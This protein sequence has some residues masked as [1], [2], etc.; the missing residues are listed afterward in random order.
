MGRDWFVQDI[1]GTRVFWHAGDTEGQHAD[2]FAIPDQRFVLVVLTNG[3][4]G[5]SAAA[6]AA[7]DAALAQFPALAPL[8]DTIGLGHALQAPPDAA[9]ITLP[10][11][12]VA[13]YA[14]RYADPGQALTVTVEGTGP[15]LS[16]EHIDQPG[17]YVDTIRPPTAPPVPVAFLAKDMADVNGARVSFVRDQEGR[18]QWVAVGL[19]LMPRVEAKA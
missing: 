1:A 4:G 14:G 9:T 19:R 8:V 6:T 17:A 15:E 16:I 3:Q 7:L 2:F 11:N 18:V 12:Q 10:A 5:G 13:E